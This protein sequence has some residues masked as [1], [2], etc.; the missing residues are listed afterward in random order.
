MITPPR[1]KEPNDISVAEWR[2][3]ADSNLGAA[4]ALLVP[5]PP[6]AHHALYLAG[7]AVEVA[8]K[9]KCILQ[10]IPLKKDHS[11]LDLLLRSQLLRPAQATTIPADVVDTDLGGVPYG[12]YFDL[13]RFLGSAWHNELRYSLASKAN[14]SEF[15]QGAREMVRWLWIA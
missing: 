13:F 14:A 8:L 5:D 7:F 9:G 3:I 2:A 4:H 6:F 12:T 1:A 11:L 10:G 15:V